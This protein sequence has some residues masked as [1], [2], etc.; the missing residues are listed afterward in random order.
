MEK[1]NEFTDSH[2][3]EEQ[4]KQN[5]TLFD[6]DTLEFPIEVIIDKYRKSLATNYIEGE[7]IEDSIIYIPDYQREFIWDV[8]RKSKFIE[9]ILLGIPIPYFFFADI[10]GRM[11]VVDGSQRIRTLEEFQSGKLKLKGLEKLTLLNKMT[12][13]DLPP[14]RK[15]RFLNK[16]L[17]A[18]FLGENTDGAARHDLFERINTGSDELKSAEIRKGAYAGPFWDFIKECSENSLFKKLCP[19]SDKV[20]L[21]AEGTERVLRFFAYSDTLNGYNGRVT[22]FLDKYM[23]NSIKTFNSDVEIELKLKFESML[24]FVNNN[25]PLGFKKAEKANST[26]RVRFEAI[27]IGVAKALEEVPTLVTVNTSWID[28]DEFRAV[29]RSDAANNKSNLVGRIDFVKLHLLGKK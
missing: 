9:S 2:E 27:A 20:G 15:R 12:F 16:G 24:T 17:K 28:S 14:I 7:E 13:W 8:E 18:I 22:L 4:I 6:F 10:L 5:I 1:V 11:E 25:F 23:K 26:P 3:I 19:I 29:T 21:R